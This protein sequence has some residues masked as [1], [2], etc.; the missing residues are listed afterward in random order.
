MCIFIEVDDN[1]WIDKSNISKME[2]EKKG[3]NYVILFFTKDKNPYILTF[4]SEK[5]A[6]NYL[7]TNFNIIRRSN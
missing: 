6:L 4:S 5:E 1:V 3:E 7:Y 2:I